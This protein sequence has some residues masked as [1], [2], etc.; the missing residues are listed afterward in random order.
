[1]TTQVP[2]MATEMANR[3]VSPAD[4]PP[5]PAGYGLVITVKG[6]VGVALSKS[7]T[8]ALPT[9]LSLGDPTIIRVPEMPTDLPKSPCWP[10]GW[11][12]MATGEFGAALARSYT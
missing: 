8:K 5:G 4:R 3:S 7:Y 10:R 11:F 1:M 12:K 6:T 2:E 9:V